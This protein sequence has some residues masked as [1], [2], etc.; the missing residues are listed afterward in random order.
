MVHDVPGCRSRV[1]AGN[2]GR[3]CRTTT[4]SSADWSATAVPTI[5]ISFFTILLT[6]LIAIPIGVYSAV[7]AILVAD[8]VLTV[9]GFIGM[10]IPQFILAL[11]LMLVAKMLFG[12]TI[13][14][15]F[16][17]QY[18][19]Q[20]FWDWPKVVDLL[21]HIW[22]PVLVIGVG[23]TAGMTASC[24]PICSTNSANDTSSLRPR[25]GRAPVEVV[26][27][28]SVSHGADSVCLRHRFAVS[29]LVSGSA[30]V[31]IILNLPTSSARSS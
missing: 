13:S 29:A 9:G 17:S 4:P 25:Q 19:M 11:V 6:W 31:E 16:S 15:L 1:V 23:G 21:K 7:R 20:S 18:A 24:A 22:V 3:R 30:I 26:A 5:T 2:L 12:V 8:Y 10:C 14:G 27:Q 28:I